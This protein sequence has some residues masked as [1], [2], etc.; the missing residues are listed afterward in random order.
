[1]IMWNKKGGQ[2]LV[3]QNSWMNGLKPENYFWPEIPAIN[4]GAIGMKGD[5]Y[6]DKT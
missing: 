5:R 2:I 4:G 3:Y 6:Q 1:M